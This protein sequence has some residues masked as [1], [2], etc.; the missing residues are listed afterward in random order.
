M[1]VP[2]PRDRRGLPIGQGVGTHRLPRRNTSGRRRGF[3]L[4]ELVAVVSIITIFAAL[5]IPTAVV[6]LRDRRVQEAARRIGLVYR[7]A[8]MHALGRGSAV[9]VRFNGGDVT[10][11]EARV[12]TA[13][14]GDANCVDLPVSSCRID[15]T[16]LANY[17]EID[18]FHKATSG[19]MSTLAVA[20]SDSD[21]N[22]VG[23]LD[24][25][26]T[27]MGRA[28]ARTSFAGTFAPIAN[29][30]VATVSRPGAGR[31]R[32]MALLPNGTARLIAQ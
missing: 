8:R 13:V 17:R 30:F 7:E 12:G 25:C 3:S 11:L 32:R 4:L 5:A 18:G 10:V 27:P 9:M 31:T 16:Q 22:A 21:G 29:A 26:F 24:V 6:Q 2:D 15:W 14:G 23:S 19:E 20:L 1:L 28:F